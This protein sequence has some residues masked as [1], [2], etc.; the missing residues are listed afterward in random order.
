MFY[1]FIYTR[2]CNKAMYLHTISFLSYSMITACLR[3]IFLIATLTTYSFGAIAQSPS[4]RNNQVRSLNAMV[5]YMDEASRIQQ[6]IYF[7]I[8]SFCEAYTQ[9][10]ENARPGAWHV[11][12]QAGTRLKSDFSSIKEVKPDAE[13]YIDDYQSRMLPFYRTKQDLTERLAKFPVKNEAVNNAFKLFRNSF[14]SMETR[15]KQMVN[16]VHTAAFKT[17]EGFAAAKRMIDELQPWFD[18]YNNAAN[19]LYTDISSYYSNSLKPLASQKIIRTA[20]EEL[21]LSVK[22][23]TEWASQLYQGDDSKRIANDAALRALQK[24]A[25][26]KA[27]S[28]LSK[29]YG[30]NYLNNGAFPHSRY[31][32]FYQNM[33]STIFWFK[34]DT[35]LQYENMPAAFENYN[36][37]VNSYNWVIH[38]Y[39]EFIECADGRTSAANM[40]YSPEMAAHVGADTAQNVLLK[41]PRIGYR[42]AWLPLQ[43][44]QTAVEY[45]VNDSTSSRR[46]SMIGSAEPH[47]TV[48]LLDVSNS[49]KEEHKLD[50]LKQGM[51]YLVTLQRAVDNISVIAFA[52]SA[53][54]LMQFKPCNEK[55]FIYKVIDKLQTSGATN[56]EAAVRD[57][58]VLVDSTLNYKGK[59]KVVIITDGQFT[60]EKTTKKKIELYKA[61]GVH[62]S[63]L[64]LGRIHDIDTIEYFK[65]LCEKGSGNFYD[66]RQYNLQEVLV[67][68][69]SD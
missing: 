65:A 52:D 10:I 58:Y 55:D 63:I 22:L 37:Y 56:A 1:C 9:N 17:D 30:Y 25:L 35:E 54:K 8:I 34:T 49:M 21:L 19:R 39:N 3:N 69:A 4:A 5:N 36:K 57:G 15:Y 68:E 2:G 33:P 53:E 40:D 28:Y 24:Q 31:M 42:F 32:M 27:E 16:Y 61:K 43:K 26:P 67:K 47:H 48:Y 12:V 20:Q 46:R 14:D 13:G 6:Q 41:M 50:T 62:L 29:T 11:A 66:M 59:T 18:K 60:L 38:Y 51:K 23:V 7:D 64:L 45:T 44:E